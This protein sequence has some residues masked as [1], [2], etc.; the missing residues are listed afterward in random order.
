MRLTC[1]AGRALFDRAWPMNVRELEQCLRAARA[2][3]GDGAIDAAHFPAPVTEPP[4][5]SNDERPR[6]PLSEAEA[7]QREDLIALLR[8]HAGSVSA[9]ARATGKA[10]MQIQRWMKR[11]GLDPSAFRS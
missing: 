9:V 7:K 10:R 6:R 3:A 2:L 1:E 11:Y 5:E 4:P 8:E